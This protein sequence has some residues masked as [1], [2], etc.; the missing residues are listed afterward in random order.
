MVDDPMLATHAAERVCTG[1][2]ETSVFHA[3]V[4]GK[5]G[6][7]ALGVVVEVVVVGVTPPPA[8][9][10]HD[11]APA[12]T[13]QAAIATIRTAKPRSIPGHRPIAARP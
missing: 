12:T 7:P 9:G 4:A 5:S 8:P 11:A 10:S 13:Q 1:E 2:A 3:L 6:H